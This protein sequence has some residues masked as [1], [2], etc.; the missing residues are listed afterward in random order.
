MTFLARTDLIWY[1]IDF[2]GT[3]VDTK[4]PDYTPVKGPRLGVHQKLNELREM[5]YKIVIHTAR[6][7][8]DYEIVE[9]YMRLWGLPWD[10]I[11]CGKLLA[12][13]Y[14]DDKNGAHIDAESW[15]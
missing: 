11:V 13:K 15:L 7:W 10:R 2:D 3:I 1:A 6:P 9:S 8:A 4:G 12:K 14:I 5:D